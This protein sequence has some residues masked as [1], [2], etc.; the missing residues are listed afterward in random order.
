M[1]LPHHTVRILCV[2]LLLPLMGIPTRRRFL[3]LTFVPVLSANPWTLLR[4]AFP[5]CLGSNTQW[6]CAVCDAA[7]SCCAMLGQST[8]FVAFVVYDTRRQ[9]AGRL[10]CLCCFKTKNMHKRPS[11]AAAV[12][13]PTAEWVRACFCGNLCKLTAGSCSIISFSSRLFGPNAE[14]VGLNVFHLILCL[15]RELLGY[16]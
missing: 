13:E 11:V 12:I 15:L 7:I 2:Y 9:E 1:M 6:H 10:D 8:L 14:R 3:L 5:P 16:P 4:Y